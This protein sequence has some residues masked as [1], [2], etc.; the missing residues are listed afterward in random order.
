MRLSV[1]GGRLGMLLG[2]DGSYMHIY[3]EIILKS[4]FFIMAVSGLFYFAFRLVLSKCKILDCD[5]RFYGM[6]SNKELSDVAS[7][8]YEGRHVN[9]FILIAKVFK[10]SFRALIIMSILLGILSKFVEEIM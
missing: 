3:F 8:C 7:K 4:L 5:F 9:Q 10:Y 6:W 2:S 1:G